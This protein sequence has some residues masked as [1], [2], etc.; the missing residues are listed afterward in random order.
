MDFEDRDFQIG[1]NHGRPLKINMAHNCLEVW[2][3]SF[4]FLNGVICRVP[5]ANLPGCRGS[6]SLCYGFGDLEMFKIG[7]DVLSYFPEKCAIRLKIWRNW[8][9]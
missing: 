1:K 8:G 3:R 2:F 6:K 7:C 4:S 9:I 5:I